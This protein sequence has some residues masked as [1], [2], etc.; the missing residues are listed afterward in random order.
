MIPADLHT[1]PTPWERGSEGFD[2]LAQAAV[3]RGVAVLGFSEHGPACHP[4]PR[5]SGLT[6]FEMEAYVREVLR[7][8]EAFSG[9]LQVFCGLELDWLP[10]RLD[11]YLKLRRTFPFDYFLVSVHRVD[12]WHVDDPASLTLSTH[13]H[14]SPEGL[15]RLY[16]SQ[17]LEAARSGLFSALAHLDYLR[18]T[19]PHSPGKPPEF[20]REMF[21]DLA[22]DL[23]DAGVAV[24][25]NT[26]GLEIVASPEPHPTLPLLR[27]LVRAGARFCLGSDAHGEERVGAGLREARNRLRDEGVGSLCYFKGFQRREMD[28]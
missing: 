5:Y 26:R 6:E 24:E 25:I 14:K 10:A 8:K 17:V 13:R 11:Y 20:A 1:H 19:L 9:H 4:H 3:E 21:P 27:S 16:Y 7:I 15:Y 2:R 23:A 18:R 22:R 12:D 28:I